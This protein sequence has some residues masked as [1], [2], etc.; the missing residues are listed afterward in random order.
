MDIVKV[1]ISSV[2]KDDF[3]M[4]FNKEREVIKDVVN[5]K[6]NFTTNISPDYGDLNPLN[7]S[8]DLSL[9]KISTADII[10]LLI[11][12][13]YGTIR[14]SGLS[15]THM[16]YRRAVDENKPIFIYIFPDNTNNQ[17]DNVQ[18]FIEEIYKND[19]CISKNAKLDIFSDPKYKKILEYKC[20]NSSVVPIEDE[21]S[22]YLEHFS[23][24]IE[25][26]IL[27]YKDKILIKLPYGV[28]K[29]VDNVKEK[30]KYKK[31][32]SNELL[33]YIKRSSFK[34]N[35]NIQD[36]FL[37][38]EDFYNQVFENNE[39]H[40]LLI[41]GE[42]G[43]GKT[44]L[45]YELGRK[46]K[47]NNYIVYLI[48]NN[49]KGWDDLKLDSSK[50][51]C[52]LFDYAEENQHFNNNV[53]DILEQ[54]YPGIHIKLVANARN[55]Y[56]LD[57]E[58]YHENL[59][60]VDIGLGNDIE[61]KYL[62]YVVNEVF[63]INDIDLNNDKYT[64]LKILA[65]K[66]SFAIFLL[67]GLV[68]NNGEQTLKDINGFSDYLAKRFSLAMEYDRTKFHEI[69]S[70]VFKLL[71]SLPIKNTNLTEKQNDIIDRLESDNWIE[72]SE[73]ADVFKLVYNDT[74]VDELFIRYFDKTKFSITRHLQNEIENLLNY[75]IKYSKFE[76]GLRVLER[77]YG[78]SKKL[79]ADKILLSKLLSKYIKYIVPIKNIFIHTS[80]LC[81]FEKLNFF[82][83]H[84]II[85]KNTHEY[86]VLLCKA[87]L[88]DKLS[89]QKKEYIGLKFKEERELTDKNIIDKFG[90]FVVPAYL[91]FY[92]DDEYINNE[93]SNWLKNS[94]K[95]T[96]SDI[97]LMAFCKYSTQLND[98]F[99]KTITERVEVSIHRHAEKYIN[100]LLAKVA[101]LKDISLFEI[102][103]ILSAIDKIDK[104]ALFEKHK[105][106]NLCTNYVK[107]NIDILIESMDFYPI[108]AQKYL[109]KFKGNPNL[110]LKSLSLWIEENINTSYSRYL[111]SSYFKNAN[112]IESLNYLFKK[113]LII[114]LNDSS[115]R[116][117]IPHYLKVGGKDKEILNYI[118]D[119]INNN[120]AVH[121]K[122]V[123]GDYLASGGSMKKIFSYFIDGKMLEIYQDNSSCVRENIEIWESYIPIE[124]EKLHKYINTNKEYNETL[125][126][127]IM[128][129]IYNYFSSDFYDLDSLIIQYE[130]INELRHFFYEAL[131]IKPTMRSLKFYLE[132]IGKL[133]DEQKPLD[134]CIYDWFLK[135]NIEEESMSLF[136]YYSNKYPENSEKLFRVLF[137]KCISMDTLLLLLEAA[138]GIRNLNKYNI[139]LEQ[140]IKTR[141]KEI[142]KPEIELSSVSINRIV[143]ILGNDSAEL[144]MFVKKYI[145]QSKD[146]FSDSFYNIFIKVLGEDSVELREVAKK[147]ISQGV[148]LAGESKSKVISI[149]EANPVDLSI[150]IKKYILESKDIFSDNNYQIIVRILGKD[151]TELQNMAKKY[152]KLNIK[153][154]S[155][156]ISR[157][158]SILGNNSMELK[159]YV[160]EYINKSE[161]IF[162]DEL[163][164]IIKE[165]LG[166][167][168]HKLKKVAKKYIQQD[169]EL[170]AE[171]KL[172]IMSMMNDRSSEAKNYAKKY[173]DG[174]EDVFSDKLYGDIVKIL[175]KSSDELKI[176]SEKYLEK[177]TRITSNAIKKAIPILGNNSNE[178]K[179]YLEKCILNDKNIFFNRFY[180]K[181]SEILGENSIVL[182]KVAK[183]YLLE[184]RK[185]TNDI[186]DIIIDIY[187][188]DVDELKKYIKN[189]ILNC[190]K[191]KTSIVAQFIDIYEVDSKEIVEFLN[192]FKK[193]DEEIT[194]IILKRLSESNNARVQYVEDMLNNL[195]TKS[196]LESISLDIKD[197]I[198]NTNFDKSILE[199]KLI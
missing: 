16:E 87:M 104:I 168:S 86:R 24:T 44:R 95:Q 62:E 171:S 170:S 139:L 60:V 120:E 152:I 18:N 126:M 161:D 56:L 70:E 93:A 81:P 103:N 158:A 3:Q 184:D 8:E 85:D 106:L 135:N 140:A 167:D 124:K 49:F 197:I 90:I 23:H 94:N 91:N 99:I 186:A 15:L 100:N 10:I 76:Y 198:V 195:Q 162:S 117:V 82:I 34:K 67:Q 96:E 138:K 182:K 107:N 98:L 32:L 183:E 26:D 64:E 7:G 66:P 110:I 80:L 52:F 12:G 101:N 68:E 154:S 30:L 193:N 116:Y 50:E 181:I 192:K 136:I 25:N 108:F 175:G 178:S 51:Y 6:I 118:G 174:M 40:A 156:S 37:T 196:D 146:I 74:I 130:N 125:K 166:D 38:E 199:K 33:P 36:D 194:I 155:K 105:Y 169:A 46:A 150:Y 97:L 113:W 102:D 160:N 179:E 137:L 114:N 112:S 19:T 53:L 78:L 145:D 5:N 1:F 75:S 188:N 164:G 22:N 21:I 165:I 57:N 54:Q 122:Y 177:N 14:D 79:S 180:G 58:I 132:K 190:Y 159:K 111:F 20:G 129:G 147:Y 47:K 119:W 72:F 9:E 176:I 28:N 143:S 128:S 121:S 127:R 123:I 61:K 163:Y 187:K 42:G 31:Y 134:D 92:G 2:F 151:A 11:G 109:N 45:M 149:F 39:Y 133:S 141:V 157:I 173:I 29:L 55:S 48:Y 131:K 35:E 89:N 73:D 69:D 153:L 41:S 144:K 191:C 4:G 172:K 59:N 83:N 185:I 189:Y 88:L 17:E 148:K 84:D 13:S 63:R 43:V 77:I 71:A 115:A 27:K 142:A 65:G